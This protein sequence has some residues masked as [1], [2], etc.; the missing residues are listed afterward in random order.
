MPKYALGKLPRKLT[1]SLIFLTLRHERT[2]I[3]YHALEK[4]KVLIAEYLIPG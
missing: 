1:F 4:K 3:F 2:S